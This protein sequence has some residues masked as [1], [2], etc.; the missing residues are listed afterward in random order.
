MELMLKT[1]ISVS[2][3]GNLDGVDSFQLS[4][5]KPKSCI[6]MEA[7]LLAMLWAKKKKEIVL[8]VSVALPFLGS[9]W[10]ALRFCKQIFG[11]AFLSKVATLFSVPS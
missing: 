6:E 2:L 3:L 10:L 5:G 7:S 8:S 4:E 9:L 11:P 1:N